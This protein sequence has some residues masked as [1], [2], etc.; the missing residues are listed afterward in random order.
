M[1]RA[2]GSFRGQRQSREKH[3]MT[4]E[5]ALDDDKEGAYAAA[6]GWQAPSYCLVGVLQARV[7]LA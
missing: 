4:F 6:D 3:A 7:K 1:Y 5:C 2:A